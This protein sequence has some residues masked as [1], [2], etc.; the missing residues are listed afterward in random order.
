MQGMLE[1]LMQ[2]I[3]L[4][5]LEPVS[6]VTVA[7]EDLPVR[8]GTLTEADSGYLWQRATE[9]QHYLNLLRRY[10]L[11]GDDSLDL[12]ALCQQVLEDWVGQDVQTSLSVRGARREVV[13]NPFWLRQAL[14]SVAL[15]LI[16]R[17]GQPTVLR[18]EVAAQRTRNRLVVTSPRGAA[19]TPPA[20][21]LTGVLPWRLACAV[22]VEHQ[23]HYLEADNATEVCTVLS[24]PRRVMPE[25]H[26][27]TAQSR[28]LRW[29]RPGRRQAATWT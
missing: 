18:C 19:A 29:L 22:L 13:G 20:R 28:W 7:G 11:P 10:P 9:I 16:Q 2:Q 27:A 14:R 17:G 21:A 3:Q 5:I 4:E 24:F 6:Q 26:R 23:A 8:G 25:A 15:R 1:T 12:C